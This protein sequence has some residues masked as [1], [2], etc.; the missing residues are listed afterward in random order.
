M[1][2]PP[3]AGQVSVPRPASEDGDED[4]A[5]DRD[6]KAQAVPADRQ[7]YNVVERLERLFGPSLRRLFEKRDA[8]SSRKGSTLLKAVDPTSQRERERERAGGGELAFA[9][10][11]DDGGQDEEPDGSEYYDSDDSFIDDAEI[12]EA[13]TRASRFH[14]LFSFFPPF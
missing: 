7:R 8:F 13:Q 5:S 11:C 9:Q 1:P 2:V 3:I 14:A 10:D 12:G 6:E 4:L